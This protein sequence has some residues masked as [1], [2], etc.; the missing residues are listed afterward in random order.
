MIFDTDILVWYLRKH[1]R[2]AAF[3]ENFPLSERHIPVI[4]Y[5]E[6]LNGCRNN[7][8]LREFRLIA[9]EAFDEVVLLDEDVSDIAVRLMERFVLSRRPQVTDVLIAATAL[10]RGEPLA[11]ANRKHFESFAGLQLKIFRP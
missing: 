6:L 8:E 4:S 7:G 9:H 5:L 1:R 10:S 11:T 3:V 2:A